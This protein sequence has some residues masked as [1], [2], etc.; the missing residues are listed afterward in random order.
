MQAS[1]ITPLPEFWYAPLEFVV[2][3]SLIK[4]YA[5]RRTREEVEKDAS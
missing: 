4:V 5:I 3:G 2:E 1:A